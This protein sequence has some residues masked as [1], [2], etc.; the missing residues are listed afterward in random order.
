MS[1]WLSVVVG[2]AAV[3]VAALGLRFAY[4]P[5]RRGI[6]NRDQSGTI[7]RLDDTLTAEIHARDSMERRHADEMKA[8]RAEHSQ[9]QIQL[10][11]LRGRLDIL[12]GDFAKD[13][14]AAIKGKV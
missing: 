11:E 8:L 12:T 7:K 5:L 14:I 1:T 6:Q 4:P 2:V 3:V 9:C 10:A 13:I